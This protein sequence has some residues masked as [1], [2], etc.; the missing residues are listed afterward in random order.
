[1]GA[2]GPL[3]VYLVCLVYLV[4]KYVYPVCPVYPVFPIMTQKNGNRELEA[5]RAR[6]RASGFRGRIGVK[7]CRGAAGNRAS[8]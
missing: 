3:L 7:S 2:F 6:T 8:G 5:L 4:G 1:M